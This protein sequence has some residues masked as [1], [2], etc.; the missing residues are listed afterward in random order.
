[1]IDAAYD[2]MKVLK[3]SVS[4]FSSSYHKGAINL[5]SLNVFCSEGLGGESNGTEKTI[6]SATIMKFIED[7]KRIELLN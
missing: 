5:T 7:L 1:M 6:D 3:A 2:K 4:G